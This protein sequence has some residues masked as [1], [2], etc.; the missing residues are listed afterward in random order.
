MDPKVEIRVNVKRPQDEAS[1]TIAAPSSTG[2]SYDRAV[3]YCRANDRTLPEGS[4]ITITVA[5]G[6]AI[7][8]P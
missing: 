8:E 7:P 5:I 1:L 4:V 6:E 2:W 3:A